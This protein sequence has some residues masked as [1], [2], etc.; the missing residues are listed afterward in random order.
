[1]GSTP[2]SDDGSFRAT[3]GRGPKTALAVLALLLCIP[4]A[5][6]AQ[7]TASL[8]VII[9]PQEAID[10]GAQW[11]VDGGAWRDSG[12]TF[13]S[14]WTQ[15]VAVDF[16]DLAQWRTPEPIQPWVFNGHTKVTTATYYRA[17]DYDVG[18]ILAQTVWVG[19][20]L[21]FFVHSEQ[22]GSS[23]T[24]TAAADPAP[25]GA[26]TTDLN[27][28]GGL[29][30]YTP[31]ASDKFPFDVTFTASLPGHPDSPIS[32]RA[33][34]TPLC[35]LPDEQLV[36]GLSPELTVPGG[37]QAHDAAD[38]Y[39]TSRTFTGVFN[40]YRPGALQA[41]TITGEEVVLEEGDENGLYERFNYAASPLK[42]A[43]I[44]TMTINADTLIVRSPLRLPGTNVVINAWELRF[45][46]GAA[47]AS[48][49]TTP[50]S[51]TTTLAPAQKGETAGKDGTPGE[52]AGDLILN[53]GSFH[54]PRS[55]LPRFILK[56]GAG[57]NAGAGRKGDDGYSP[58]D[59]SYLSEYEW[60]P[61]RADFGIPV[62]ETI[63]YK[64]PED[65]PHY[66]YLISYVSN[67][68]PWPWESDYWPSKDSAAKT[69]WPKN[70][71]NAIPSGKPG[72]GG[73][74]GSVRATLDVESCVD[75]S[76]GSPGAR[77]LGDGWRGDYWSG[78]NEGD[79]RWAIRL[80]ITWTYWFPL[81]YTANIREE[82]NPDAPT[83][84]GEIAYVPYADPP[85]P[86]GDLRTTSTFTLAPALLRR[87]LASA[88]DEYLFG[89]LSKAETRL[90]KFAELIDAIESTW[91]PET[92]YNR[93]QLE[94]LTL[95]DEMRTL[96]HRIA[97]NLDYFGNP[98]GW[99][100]MLSFEV[101][102]KA[103]SDE[104]DHA[105]N[106]M[107]L[108]YWVRNMNRDLRDRAQGMRQLQKALAAEVEKL[109]TA[110]A[111][112]VET[113]PWIETEAANITAKTHELREESLALVDELERQ[114]ARNLEP[115]YW[116]KVL[117]GAQLGAKI[118]GAL[119]KVFPIGQPY[120]GAVGGVFD[121][122]G[123][124]DFKNPWGSGLTATLGVADLTA[125]FT[126]QLYKDKL[127]E[128][129]KQV[130]KVDP[131][132]AEISTRTQ[133]LNALAK[134]TA[135]LSKG[136]KGV[137]DVV[138]KFKVPE[139]DVQAE[140]KKLIA[141]SKEFKDIALKIEDL[142]EKKKVFMLKLAAATQA[143][144][145]FPN[146]ISRDM[147]AINTLAR[148]IDRAEAALSPETVG[149]INEIERRAR[150]RL[151]K[152][153]YY[154][155]KAYEYRILRPYPGRLDLEEFNRNIL[156]MAKAA[157]STCTLTQQD[158]E[159]LKTPYREQI[160][161]AADSIFTEYLKGR[162][163]LS[164]PISFPLTAQQI[165]QVNSGEPLEINLMEM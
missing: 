39:V 62:S 50:L 108:G 8:R 61:M 87:I 112:A 19:D 11:R 60:G 147:L 72:R 51:D 90:S 91:D 142:M 10:A 136:L 109:K 26:M 57:Q 48:L 89:D 117:M 1:M 32:Q 111:E 6:E 22:L 134:G 124:F 101:G 16:Q 21:Q 45:E 42:N 164:A 139:A 56:G 150:E 104:I 131:K 127:A 146:L 137:T 75:R 69:E 120:V 161:E 102:S 38:V 144:T 115:S 122:F 155:A 129:T 15:R 24:L 125:T 29:F 81:Y 143:V 78:G 99:V 9:A 35:E 49:C 4:L 83:M 119:A 71:E 76:S 140:L 47:T 110:Y 80:W 165:E 160:R 149:Y 118:S 128:V 114:A 23:A 92:D 43:D 18:D 27:T 70:G 163:E 52:K 3:G 100:P 37:G 138:S 28:S 73:G 116:E 97:S 123:N 79:P 103:F 25:V 132:D 46:D 7:T 93:T 74:G 2:A 33:T 148:E 157:S 65:L 77:A 96:L 36:F 40:V 63:N 67:A 5:A 31:D 30:A 82:K 14:Q 158:F 12:T 126:D 151:L 84:P 130:K 159:A 66:Y 152:Y 162:I 135:A 44:S 153:H 95:R 121:V 94:M 64:P 86:P 98:A 156:N 88:K 105:V 53:I 13:T 107:Y 68:V 154:M 55:S 34:I 113:I 141:E 17:I 106:V 58:T 59:G 145:E 85:G 41:V 133:T 54:A 20:T